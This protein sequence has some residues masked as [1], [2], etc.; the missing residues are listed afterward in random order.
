MSDEPALDAINRLADEEMDLRR[1]ESDSTATDADRERIEE[2]ELLLD[3]CWDL[4]RQ[5]RARTNAGLDP[6]DAHT[7]SLSTVENFEQ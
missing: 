7:R 2:I 5:R 3:Q 1:K 6:D 4:L